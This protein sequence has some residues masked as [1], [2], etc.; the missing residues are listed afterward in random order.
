MNN[1]TQ[2]VASQKPG[3][4]GTT[5][6]KGKIKGAPRTGR[7]KIEEVPLQSIWTRTKKGLEA[8]AKAIGRGT[9]IAAQKTVTLGKEA[10]LQYQINTN[11]YKLQKLLAELGGR[12]YDLAKINPPELNLNDSQ[13]LTTIKRVREMDERIQTFK[14]KAKA[15]KKS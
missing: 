9:E 3:T 8:A 11:H 10:G 1:R 7:H 14:Q 2:N 13:A 5:G 6:T 4:T 12:I 15:L